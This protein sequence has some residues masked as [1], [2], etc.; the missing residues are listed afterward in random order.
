MLIN[1]VVHQLGLR[2]ADIAVENI[3]ECSLPCIGEVAMFAK[4]NRLRRL[5]RL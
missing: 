1:C 4:P 2:L 3:R 5:G